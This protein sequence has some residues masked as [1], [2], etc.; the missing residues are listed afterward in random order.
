MLENEMAEELPEM[1]VRIVPLEVKE[2]SWAKAAPE[3]VAWVAG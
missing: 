3:A 1:P 2:A